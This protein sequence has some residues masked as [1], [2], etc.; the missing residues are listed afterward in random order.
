MPDRAFEPGQSPDEGGCPF[1]FAKKLTP[2]ELETLRLAA[3]GYSSKGMARYL[4]IAEVTA[5]K[6]LQAARE[7]LGAANTA[8][9]VYLALRSGLIKF[10]AVTAC[11]ASRFSGEPGCEQGFPQTAG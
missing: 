9:A 7:A 2:R 6:H 5:K 3:L 8:N 10:E 1:F 11:E 4:S